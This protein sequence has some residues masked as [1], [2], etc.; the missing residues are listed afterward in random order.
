MITIKEIADALNFS[1]T[2]VSVCL[3][4]RENDPRYRIRAENAELIRSFARKHGYV[5]DLSAR[6]LRRS[7]GGTPPV[8]I[9]FSHRSGFEK[10]F[11]AIRHAMDTLAA[12]GRE[13]VVLGYH[14]SHLASFEHFMVS[15]EDV[16]LLLTNPVLLI[17]LA[18][19]NGV[20]KG[21]TEG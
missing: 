6:R 3:S 16:I 19:W 14:L 12:H 2:T 9:V 5:P 17:L 11:P 13:Y 8:G 10:S 20:L 15:V 18:A 4:G 1:T 21:F 7:G